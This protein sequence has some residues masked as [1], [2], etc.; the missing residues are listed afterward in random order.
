MNF[1]KVNIDCWLV[2]TYAKCGNVEKARMVF[3]QMHMVS[4]VLL[5]YTQNGQA[6]EALL[7][8]DEMQDSGSKPNPVTALI[9]VCVCLPGFRSPWKETPQFYH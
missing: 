7:L 9:G 6:S 2:A 4:H 3:G 5:G 8:F 1:H